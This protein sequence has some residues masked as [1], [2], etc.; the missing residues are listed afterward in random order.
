[1]PKG[2]IK[3]PAQEKK[4]ERAK[5]IA[6]EQGKAKR[7]PLVMHIFKQMDGMSKVDGED[8]NVLIERALAGQGR[9]TAMP[10][11]VHSVL[12]S[13]WNDNKAKALT[14]EQHQRLADVKAAKNKPKPSL[15]LVKMRQLE[16]LYKALNALRNV[17]EEELV[18]EDRPKSK[19][20]EWKLSELHTP[21]E[22]A[23]IQKFVDQGYHPREAAH[24]IS[25]GRGGKGEHR[26]F[27]KALESRI[28][29]TML[30]EKMLADAKNVANDWLGNYEKISGKYHEPEKNP[31][32][33]ASAQ[34][35]AAH[36][37][38]T[39]KYSKA[40]NDFLGSDELKGKSPMERHKTVQAWKAKWKSENPEHE[41]GIS[42][43]AEAG[44]KFKEAKQARSQHIKDVMEHLVHGGAPIEPASGEFDETP[45]TGRAVA[46]H[47]GLQEK[48]GEGPQYSTSKDPSLA[49]AAKN[50]KFIQQILA[51]KVE[52]AKQAASQ[53]SAAESAPQ[54][55][56]AVSTPAQAEPKPEAKAVIRRT[57]KPEQIERMSRIDAA[58]MATKKGQ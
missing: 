22:L 48:E 58:K 43:V 33:Y 13:W 1:M 25:G 10:D 47:M 6:A 42:A 45:T 56:V 26:D 2:V 18:K 37:D 54:V 15:K 57:A 23:E 49:F 8:K 7:W 31:V 24:L 14:P 38:R 53:A 21:Q 16:D 51:P 55:P 40:Y 28:R 27:S 29:P 34:M 50:P 36:E 41:A 46:E 30:S 39:A 52:Q 9:K 12:H 4:W 5:E 35:K 20:N 32:K 11:E 17:V 44:S 19:A 3:T